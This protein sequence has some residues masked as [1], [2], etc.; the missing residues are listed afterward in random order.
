MGNGLAG[1]GLG[2]QCDFGWS[3]NYPRFVPRAYQGYATCVNGDEWQK[4]NQNR[5][6]IRCTARWDLLVVL[7]C[8]R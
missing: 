4:A 1:Y 5:R 7:C 8:L 2:R 6:S 3:E